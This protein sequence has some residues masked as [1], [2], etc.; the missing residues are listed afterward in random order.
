MARPLRLHVPG[1]LFHVISRGNAKQVIFVGSQDYEHF[2]ALLARVTVR[3][4]VHCNAYCL[5]PNHFHL[6]L[7]PTALPLSRMM[8]QLNS[9]YGQWF[10]R[11]HGRVGHV[12]QGRFKA[13]LVDRDTY[14]LQLLRY[15]VLNPVR[16]GAVD[17]PAAWPWSSYRA[18]AGMVAPSFLTL[19][20]AWQ[21]F[22]PS[23]RHRAQRRFVAFVAAA[24]NDF[25]PTDSLVAGAK[26][27]SAELAPQME[28]HRSD[29]DIVYKEKHASRPGLEQVLCTSE[30]QVRQ[31]AA[32]REAFEVH[33]YTLGEIGAF[34]NRHPSTI[35]RHIQR[36]PRDS[37]EA[38]TGRFRV[39]KI[40]I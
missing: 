10:N 40:K 20:W 35:W 28:Q 6:M 31:D 19:D 29:P 7:A 39:H 22:D 23:D 3:F 37:R 18:M 11:R 34:L 13:M 32:V 15:I 2:L 4:S 24:D 27:F 5:M 9:A 21:Q 38:S 16:A 33:G 36:A 25:K 17:Q 30:D 12:L 1:A 8:Q 14:F 26:A